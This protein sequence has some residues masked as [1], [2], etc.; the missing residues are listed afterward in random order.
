[1]DE[2]KNLAGAADATASAPE[3]APAPAEAEEK[4]EN[5]VAAEAPET[6][7]PEPEVKEAPAEEVPEKEA[8]PAEEVKCEAA[9]PE[10]AEEAA[11]AEDAPATLEAEGAE[12][13]EETGEGADASAP[14]PANK[15]EVIER[16]KNI[17]YDKENVERQELE[18]LKMLYYRYHNAEVLAAREAFLEGGGEAEAFMPPADPTEE[19]FKAQYALIREMRNQ[20]A[21]ELE[22][23]KQKNLERKQQ[24]IERLKELAASPEAADKGFEEFSNLRNEWKEI[25]VVPAEN[26]TELWKN[27]QLYV[28]QFYDQLHLNHEMRAYDFKKNLEIKT[29]LCE[30][31]EKLADTEDVISAFHQLQKLHQEFRET[32]PVS[33][34]LREEIWKRFKEA[35]TVVNK[36]HQEHFENLKAREEENLRLKTAL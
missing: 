1:M 22:A 10:T 14:L 32:G 4:L 28:E 12:E 9:T 21:R 15:Q 31:A 17:V 27:Y 34:E 29:H 13:A 24:I 2:I 8:A 11:P 30:A 35:S 20:A 19:D 26:A 33:K 3:A 6:S 7:A 18:R 5:A 36:R 25:K 16:L 23:E